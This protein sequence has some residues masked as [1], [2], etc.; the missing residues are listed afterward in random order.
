L[1]TKTNNRP[2]IGIGLADYWPMPIVK[3]P[4]LIIGKLA[5][6]PPIMGGPLV[7]I[8]VVVSITRNYQYFVRLA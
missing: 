2:I 7:K 8:N 6:N 1:L 5:D 4:I 3:W